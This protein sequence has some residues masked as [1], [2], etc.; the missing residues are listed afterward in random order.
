METGTRKIYYEDTHMLDFTARILT[1]GDETDGRLSLVLDQTSF[2]PEE[3]GQKADR[4]TLAGFPVLDVQ[5]RNGVISHALPAGAREAIQKAARE[6][7]AV[8]GHVDWEQRFDFMQQHT[9]EHIL[10][11]LVH[12]QFGYRNVGFHLGYEEVTLDFDGVLS[13][14]EIREIEAEANRI[15]H[16][17]L[18]VLISFPSPEVLETLQYRSKIEI[19]EAVRI[20]EIP[21]VDTCACCAPHVE[22]TGQIG[23]IKV[24]GLQSHRGGVRVSILCGMRAVRDYTKKQE[25]IT[26]LSVLLSAKPE[27]VGDAVRRLMEESQNRRLRINALQSRLLAQRLLALPAASPGA[28]VFLFEETL[29]PKAVRDAV[30][31]MTEKYGGYCGIFSGSDAEGYFYVIGSR[32]LDCRAAADLLRRGCS[33]KGGGSP[34][35]VQGTVCA[36][37]ACI[38]NTLAGLTPAAAP[39][40]NP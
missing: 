9:G 38:Q 19:T 3:G 12:G 22:S 16:R 18:P 15:I 7:A 11:G 14:E 35:M 6:N 34:R 32:T 5:I 40:S 36:P 39:E 28:P 13:P 4:G 27:A 33:A 26:D 37:M 1:C 25:S 20:V 29:D 24:T 23:L 2:F 8:A 21:G 17:N 10:S 31:G 30:N